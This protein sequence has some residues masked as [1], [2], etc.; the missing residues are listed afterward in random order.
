MM[1]HNQSFYEGVSSSSLF[2][3]NI[4]ILNII[5]ERETL[6]K[7]WELFVALEKKENKSKDRWNVILFLHH[8]ERS[9]IIKRMGRFFCCLKCLSDAAQGERAFCYLCARLVGALSAPA[10][11]LCSPSSG[12]SSG[13]SPERLRDLC[14]YNTTLG[15]SRKSLL[16]ISILSCCSS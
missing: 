8:A 2:M 9:A 11:G 12:S 10:G 16:F 15:S 7:V 5:K 13:G 6:C 1:W 4:Y 14:R 3:A